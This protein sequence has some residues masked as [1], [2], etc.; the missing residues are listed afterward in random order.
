MF[1]RP[2][3][4]P[5]IKLK[6]MQDLIKY[7][8]TT[9][10]VP[11]ALPNRFQDLWNHYVFTD[12]TGKLYLTPYWEDCAEQ[13]DQNG[14]ETCSLLV[15]PQTQDAL[16]ALRNTDEYKQLDLLAQ[17]ESWR[18]IHNQCLEDAQ[19][20]KVQSFDIAKPYSR[21]E[22]T[23]APVTFFIPEVLPQRK[24]IFEG[25]VDFTPRQQ[26]RDTSF[27]GTYLRYSAELLLI[28]D[29]YGR[30]FALP[31]VAEALDHLEPH[32][33]YSGFSQNE[34]IRANV[35]LAR[36]QQ[37]QPRRENA[38]SLYWRSPFVYLSF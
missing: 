8:F 6:S 33:A 35:S 10:S 16:R 14:Y 25:L 18:R 12:S 1:D 24:V 34:N 7:S 23:H 30:S 38:I 3:S 32:L 17:Q 20:R 5:Q 22:A 26:N 19:K 31:N 36:S 15:N 9:S 13:F 27:A 29:E 4:P 37:H 21:I 11:P 2:Q 28:C